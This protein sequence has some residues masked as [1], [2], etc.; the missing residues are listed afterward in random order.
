MGN[1]QNEKRPNKRMECI[2]NYKFDIAEQK[3]KK[4]ARKKVHKQTK[5]KKLCEPKLQSFNFE[6][7]K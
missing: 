5:Q 3:K 2:F 4:K 7:Q 6:K 1:S